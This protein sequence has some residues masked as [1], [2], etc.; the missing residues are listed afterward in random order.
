M[1]ETDIARRGRSNLTLDGPLRTLHVLETL[2]SM[3]QPASLPAIAPLPGDMVGLSSAGFGWAHPA[4]AAVH[5]NERIGNNLP[6]C[7]RRWKQRL[8]AF[9]SSGRIFRRREMFPSIRKRDPRIQSRAAS[10]R[11]FQS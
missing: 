11:V 2:A 6:L 9:G 4:I 7:W 10:N 5:S 1:T 3:E 8:F